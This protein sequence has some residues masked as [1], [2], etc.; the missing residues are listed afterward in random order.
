MRPRV[1]CADLP[2]VATPAAVF[3]QLIAADNRGEFGPRA[4]GAIWLDSGVL[5][6]HGRSYLALST[7][8]VL[9]TDLAEPVFDWMHREL[10]TTNVD[11]SDA[12]DGFTLGWVGWLGYELRGETMGV[13]VAVH[14]SSA[15]AAWLWVDR[16]IVYDHEANSLSVV[17]LGA[18]WEGEL[19]VWRDQ[20]S[21]LVGHAARTERRLADLES[22]PHPQPQHPQPQ[23]PQPPH[24]H[25]HPQPADRTPVATWRDSDERYLELIARCQHSIMEGDAYQLCLT[26]S[27]RIEPAPDALTTYLRLRLANPS[28]H[29]G[30]IQVGTTTLLSSSPEQFL[31]ISASRQV[32]TKPIK[33][34]RR[35]DAD[36]KTDDRLRKELLAS[37]KERAENL[38]IVDLMR[39]DLGRVCELGSVTVPSLFA[40]ESY[41]TVHQLVSCVSGQLRSDVTA[42]DAIEA[43]F[44]AGSMTGAPKRSATD[45]LDTLEAAPRG[46]YSGVFGYVGLDGAVDLAMVIRSIVM[47]DSGATIGA[48]GGITALSVPSEELAEVKLKA[49]ALLSV[50]GVAQP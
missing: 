40:V 4:H 22:A 35:R 18:A 8:A 17:A 5:A 39:N 33:G 3:E 26:T 32:V 21:R 23:H 16:M 45:I 20:I 27:V 38:M 30:F 34:T 48:G 11:V 15:D 7:R 37:D 49:A 50:L 47:D 1:L 24:P 44:P 36:P 10:V 42:I 14:P 12:P 13:E 19:L 41:A 43:T 6:Q 28:H 46:L 9:S 29:G 2:D 31:A 25:S